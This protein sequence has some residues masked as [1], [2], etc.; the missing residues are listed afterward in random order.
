MAA[1]RSHDG[2]IVASIAAF[3]AGLKI[4][5][6]TLQQVSLGLLVI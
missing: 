6:Y 1:I 5:A 4:T 2:Y 3:I